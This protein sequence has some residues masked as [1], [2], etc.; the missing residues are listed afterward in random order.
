MSRKRLIITRL[1]HTGGDNPFEPACGA[2]YERDPVIRFERDK[3]TCK[4]CL[5]WLKAR[6][7]LEAVQDRN[8]VWT[9]AGRELDKIMM[10]MGMQR[11]MGE[12]DQEFRERARREVG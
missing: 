9:A 1:I 12:T 10:G 5:E 7:V 11:H 4:D 8:P 3:I 6:E 2:N